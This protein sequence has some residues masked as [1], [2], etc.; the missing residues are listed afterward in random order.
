MTDPDA[1]HDVLADHL[2]AAPPLGCDVLGI[3]ALGSDAFAIGATTASLDAAIRRR[4]RV[5]GPTALAVPAE[6]T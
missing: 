5:L 1:L 3:M 4:V 6:P 2:D